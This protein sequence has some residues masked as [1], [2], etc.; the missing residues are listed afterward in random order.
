VRNYKNKKKSI[1]QVYGDIVNSYPETSFSTININI[2]Y[3]SIANHLRI[4]QNPLLCQSPAKIESQI[5]NMKLVIFHNNF[6]LN[7]TQDSHPIIPKVDFNECYLS[8]TLSKEKLLYFSYIILKTQNSL[9]PQSFADNP[10]FKYYLTLESENILYGDATVNRT[11]ITVIPYA[12]EIMEDLDAT[13]EDLLS[14][15][16]ALYNYKREITRRY[17]DIFEIMGNIGGLSKILMLFG[18][19]VIAYYANLRKKEALM[20]ELYTNK[21]SLNLEEFK[22]Q[23]LKKNL[24][25]IDAEVIKKVFRYCDK[26]FKE[27]GGEE[28]KKRYSAENPNIMKVQLDLDADN[29]NNVNNINV[30]SRESGN[31]VINN[32]FFLEAKDAITP[33]VIDED[34]KRV[35]SLFKRIYLEFCDEQ[36]S[37]VKSIWAVADRNRK[38]EFYNRIFCRAFVKFFFTHKAQQFGLINF[39]LTSKSIEHKDNNTNKKNNNN[40]NNV[41]SVQVSVSDMNMLAEMLEHLEKNFEGNYA[42]QANFSF[43]MVNYINEVEVAN[44]KS[45]IDNIDTKSASKFG[46]KIYEI[47]CLICCRSCATRNFKR[48]CKEF[49]SKYEEFLEQTDFNQIINSL[50]EFKTFKKTF[51]EKGQLWLFDSCP[52][53]SITYED[54]DDAVDTKETENQKALQKKISIEVFIFF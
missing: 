8:R 24:K 49:E 38:F 14:V 39:N 22:E 15:M 29:Y 51:F 43:S 27:N 50:Q 11:G 48:R 10:E 32:D 28:I 37:E 25:C 52:I 7:S 46:F 40:D 5:A 42:Q 12:P 9:I 47:F 31:T 35:N 6:L 33:E 30:E 3:N 1:R 26:E 41:E 18:F 20:N 4:A 44:Y 36:N 13:N 17:R 34:A 54:D 23:K 53:K 19:C 45:L 2:L 21:A 16:F